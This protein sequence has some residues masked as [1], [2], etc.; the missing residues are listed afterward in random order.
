MTVGPLTL[1]S[2]KRPAVGRMPRPRRWQAHTSTFGGRDAAI[3]CRNDPVLLRSAGDV[4]D[5]RVRFPQRRDHGMVQ[6]GIRR[7]EQR[8]D[9]FWIHERD[10][11]ECDGPTS[12]CTRLSGRTDDESLP[13][14]TRSRALLASDFAALGKDGRFLEAIGRRIVANASETDR[15]RLEQRLRG[16]YSALKTS[17]DRCA[18]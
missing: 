9:C 5:V 16:V 6:S 15:M 17:R 10:R 1:G 12:R 7:A 8:A 2:S 13:K 18:G 4:V 3:C 11:V 14:K